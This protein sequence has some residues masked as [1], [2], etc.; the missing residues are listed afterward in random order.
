M[1][2]PWARR[3]RANVSQM[4]SAAGP[5]PGSAICPRLINLV[6]FDKARPLAV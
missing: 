1:G 5:T 6:G 2:R 4:P 3:K